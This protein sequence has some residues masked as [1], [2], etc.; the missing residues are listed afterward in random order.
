METLNEDTLEGW[1]EGYTLTGR[2]GSFATYASFVQVIDFMFN[3]HAKWLDKC[4]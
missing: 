1:L 4:M 3:Q 2:H